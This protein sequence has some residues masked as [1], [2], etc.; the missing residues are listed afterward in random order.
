MTTILRKIKNIDC[1]AVAAID[2][3]HSRLTDR[4]IQKVSGTA[5]PRLLSQSG[6]SEQSG[7]SALRDQIEQAID[8]L[9]EAVRMADSSIFVECHYSNSICF[10]FC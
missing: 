2:L 1:S 6:Q 3:H 4:I 5:S 9:A 7:P 10:Q 8:H